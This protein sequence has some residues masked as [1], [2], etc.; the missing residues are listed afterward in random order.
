MPN[1]PE[2]RVRI[3]DKDN[4]EWTISNIPAKLMAEFNDRAA[5]MYPGK[6]APWMHLILDTISSVCDVDKVTYQLTD[7]P[8]DMMEQF[9]AKLA[10]CEYTRYSVISEMLQAAGKN[11]FVVGRLNTDQSAPGDSLA[12]VIMGVPVASWESYQKMAEEAQERSGGKLFADRPPSAMGLQLIMLQ[13]AGDESFT[14]TWNETA[15]PQ[16]KPNAKSDVKSN[17]KRSAGVKRGRF[18]GT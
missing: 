6:D 17:A 11:N 4:K 5:E 14:F 18:S 9:D 13:M 8:A 7:I 3:V 12:L 10:E 2:D 15:P 1:K 16:G